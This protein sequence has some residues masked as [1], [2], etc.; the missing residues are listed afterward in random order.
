MGER[1][2]STRDEVVGGG[3]PDDASPRDAALR[4]LRLSVQT[5]CA[6]CRSQ[7]AALADAFGL[8]Q[9]QVVVLL[10]VAERET[11]TMGQIGELTDLPTSSLTAL[12]D[13][14]VDRD[15]VG[16][17]DHPGDRRVVLVRLTAAGQA[18][19]RRIMAATIAISAELM[20]GIDTATIVRVTRD[21]QR[22]LTAYSDY[23]TRTGGESLHL[24]G[25]VTPDGRA[26]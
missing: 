13:R 23:A 22:L 14:L 16:R 12:V 10:V 4:S 15:L 1:T 24:T 3:S 25:G 6:V 17:D 26:G 21:L 7:A 2:G 9:P 18:L 20:H 8:S 5:F 11:V 19:A